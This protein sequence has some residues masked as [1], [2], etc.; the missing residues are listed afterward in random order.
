MTGFLFCKSKILLGSQYVKNVVGLSQLFCFKY[1]ESELES[2]SVKD[3]SRPFGGLKQSLLRFGKQTFI[4][5]G[6]LAGSL[7]WPH[8]GMVLEFT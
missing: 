1:F 3:L 4:A 6:W 8:N 2:S 5:V 7:I